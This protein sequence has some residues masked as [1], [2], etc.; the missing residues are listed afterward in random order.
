MTILITL[1]QYSF[2]HLEILQCKIGDNIS[3]LFLVRCYLFLSVVL[4]VDGKETATSVSGI[5]TSFDQIFVGGT[6]SS[7][8]HF[9]GCMS[10]LTFNGRYNYLCKIV[11]QTSC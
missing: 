6:T 4:I 3:P 10:T 7:L 5:S 9:R 8:Q 11:Q 2:L 1:A